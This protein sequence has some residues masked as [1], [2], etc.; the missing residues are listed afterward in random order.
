[1][2]IS[3][4]NQVAVKFIDSFDFS[5]APQVTIITGEEGIGKTTLLHYLLEKC[6]GNISPVIFADAQKYSSKYCF[7]ASSGNL[8]AFR[9]YFRSAKLLIL[10]NIQFFRV[11]IKPSRSSCYTVDTF[12]S[13]TGQNCKRL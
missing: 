13:C 6:R 2:F 5:Q 4:Y 3:H 8:S 12:S 10:D 11:K 9:Q 7:A 1:M